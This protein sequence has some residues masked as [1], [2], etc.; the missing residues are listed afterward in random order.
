MMT[1]MGVRFRPVDGF[2]GY[3]VGNDGSVWTAWTM[4]HGGPGK[5]TAVIGCKWRPIKQRPDE[6]G[7][8]EVQLYQ[9]GR[10]RHRRVHHLVLLAFIGPR[11]AGC[12]QTRHL[13]GDNQNNRPRN[14]RWGTPTQN[15]QDRLRHGTAV[16]NS[17][18]KHGLH[19]LTAAEVGEILSLKGSGATQRELAERFHVVRQTISDIWRGRSWRC[20]AKGKRSQRQPAV[21]HR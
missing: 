12:T 5:T 21:R 14:L 10:P 9:A 15:Y 4:V 8:L 1:G 18:E 7:Y 6:D 20:H 17:G 11:P 13:D 3:R 19:K 2:P 16:D